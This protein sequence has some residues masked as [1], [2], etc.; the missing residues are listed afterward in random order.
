VIVGAAPQTEPAAMTEW[1]E[2]GRI[3]SPFGIEGG[4]HIDSF[5]D[6]PEA[7][8]EYEAWHIRGI[9]YQVVE[10]R[11]QG[12][13]FVVFFDG[14]E[15]RDAA[16]KLTGAMIEVR[17]EELPPAGEREFYVADL[18]GLRVTN[19]EGAEL[20]TVQYFVNG[21]AQPVMLI[22]GAREH[23]VPA[24]PQHLHKVDLKAGTILVDWP[25]ELE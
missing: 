25:E 19:L 10:A 4:M 5:T 22:K 3:G 12:K 20:G 2:L 8:F 13:R 17:R 23:L 9:D 15:D 11:P 14:I 18:I 24:V 7:L 21:T 6:P 1:V 16:A